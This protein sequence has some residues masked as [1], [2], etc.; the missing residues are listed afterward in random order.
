[1]SITKPWYYV[2]FPNDLYFN[3][4][5]VR[6]LRLVI[7]DETEEIKGLIGD[8]YA[9]LV[10]VW[11]GNENNENNLF[12]NKEI[13]SQYNINGVNAIDYFE[14]IWDDKIQISTK[15]Y[16]TNDFIFGSGGMNVPKEDKWQKISY[17]NF[18]EWRIDY[19]GEKTERIK[20]VLLLSKEL[21]EKIDEIIGNQLD[22]N[23]IG[24]FGIKD[25]FS[26][27]T[28]TE[29]GPFLD[30]VDV[31]IL[32]IAYDKVDNKVN[33]SEYQLD[34]KA[35]FENK[36]S[37][38][39]IR[40]NP[41]LSGNIKV[42]VD[43]ENNVWLNSIDANN[44]LANSRYKRYKVSPLSQYATD[45]YRFFDNGQTPPDIVFDLKQYDS[46]YKFTKQEYYLQY[47]NFYGC[48]VQRMSNRLYSEEF[49]FLAPIWLKKTLPE[50]FVIFKVDHPISLASYNNEEDKEILKDVFKNASILKTFDLREG[51]KIGNYLRNIVN[52]IR[53]KEEPLFIT[54]D[55]ESLSTWSGI[56]YNDGN[57]TEK[58]E[59][60]YNIFTVDRTIKEFEEYITEGFKR[61]SIICQNLINLE[62][63]FNDDISEE[64]SINR[65]F[66]FFVNEIELDRFNPSE[67]ILTKLFEQ[68]P[69]PRKGID[70]VPY[71]MNSFYQE[72]K[73]G[74]VLP[75]IESDKNK[76]TLEND[77]D[78][79]LTK[80]SEDKGKILTVRNRDNEFYRIQD[81]QNREDYKEI[82]LYDNKVDI[83][84]FAGID[85]FSSMLKADLLDESSA[86]M[87]IHLYDTNKDQYI[88]KPGELL[89]I[90]WQE[91]S[92]FH[93][94]E[95]I[96]NE[97]AIQPEDWWDFPIYNNDT[98]TYQNTFNP[99]G[100]PE[101][102]AKAIAGCIN[103][104][105]SNQFEAIAIDNKVFIITIKKFVGGNLFKLKRTFVEGSSIMNVKYYDKEPEVKQLYNY[106]DYTVQYDRVTEEDILLD[107]TLILGNIKLNSENKPAELE[108]EYFDI[109][110]EVLKLKN[111]VVSELPEKGNSNYFYH[112]FIKEDEENEGIDLYYIWIQ[113]EFKIAEFLD[114]YTSYNFIGGN[115]RKRNRAKIE[116]INGSNIEEN[117]WFQC[118]SQK[119]SKI[120]SFEIG[121]SRDLKNQF[122]TNTIIVLPY[123]DEPIRGKGGKL[124]GFQDLE[125][126]VSIQL[127]DDFEFYTTKE[128]YISAYK[129]FKTPISI[130]SVLPIKDFDFDFFF[131]DYSY[132]PTVELLKYFEFYE[133]KKGE[134]VELSNNEFFRVIGGGGTLLGYKNG[135]WKDIC[136]F[137]EILGENV[138][139]TIPLVLEYQV[140]IED[141]GDVPN[142]F[143]TYKVI[144]K[145]EKFKVIALENIKDTKIVKY[146]Y[147]QQWNDKDFNAKRK[148]TLDNLDYSMLDFPGF[149]GLKGLI[150]ESGDLLQ[151]KLKEN[152]D[153]R[154]FLLPFLKTEYDYLLENENKYFVSKSRVVPYI[155]KWVHSGTDVHDNNYR[156]NISNAFGLTNFS[157]STEILVDPSLFTH[158]WYYLDRHPENYPIE[159]LENSRSYMFSKLDEIPF[160]IPEKGKIERK[161][162]KTWKEL[163]YFSREDDPNYFLKYFTEGYPTNISHENLIIK[164]KSERYVFTEFIKG[165][166]QV[167]CL[168]RGARLR[169]NELDN[170]GEIIKNSKKYQGYKFTSILT[171]KTKEFYKYTPP[172]SIEVIDNQRFKTITFIIS[173]FIQDYKLKDHLSYSSLYTLNSVQKIDSAF[174]N[175]YSENI[176]IDDRRKIMSNNQFVSVADYDDTQ[177][178]LMFRPV[179]NIDI[180]RKRLKDNNLIEESF[181]QKDL[182]NLEE[183]FNLKTEE[184]EENQIIDFT[185]ICSF[186]K[187]L[188]K[189]YDPLPFIIATISTF[190]SNFGYKFKFNAFLPIEGNIRKSIFDLL[191]N[192]IIVD[193]TAIPSTK[194][195]LDYIQ[196]SKNN[197]FNNNFN[198]IISINNDNTTEVFALNG[199]KDYNKEIGELIS[200]N[201]I[202]NFINFNNK[203]VEYISIES[204][205]TIHNSKKGDQ[206][207]SLEFIEPNEFAKFDIM[208]PIIDS[209]IPS[210]L[211]THQVIGYDTKKV[212][213]FKKLQRYGGFYGPKSKNI[214]KYN[215]SEK[216][217]VNKFFEKDFTLLNTTLNFDI[218]NNSIIKN[219]SINKITPDSIPI[220]TG[221]LTYFNKY[222]LVNKVAIDNKNHNIVLSNW[223]NNYYRDYSINS[224]DFEEIE[225]IKEMQEI[226]SYFGGKVMNIKKEYKLD[227]FNNQEF[228]IELISPTGNNINTKESTKN[229]FDGGQLKLEISLDLRNRMIRYLFADNIEKEFYW[230]KNNSNS[231][232]SEKTSNEISGIVQNY[233]DKNIIE[234]FEIDS[235]L[236]YTKEEIRSYEINEDENNIIP[237]R[238]Y[239]LR[240]EESEV[241]LIKQGFRRD[242]SFIFEKNDI[243]KLLAK[244]T[245]FL[246][247]NLYKNIGI[248][249]KL[250]RI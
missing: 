159:F 76:F 202:K 73:N 138:F 95:M 29:F 160:P 38:M 46:E 189:S 59:N 90:E 82:K 98:F 47:D 242:K 158:E 129:I 198:F 220:I 137:S 168:F 140:K 249:T 74:V 240:L 23:D 217:T 149:S 52:N 237:E 105:N 1:M 10:P 215:L 8:I 18:Y 234:I 5:T 206:V 226:K 51:T 247:T 174:R 107:S 143:R 100:R 7:E 154:R 223:D 43:S 152:E 132:T 16:G 191:S 55:K 2:N 92:E 146:L 246:D 6:F 179:G 136:E 184:I 11:L 221:E 170:L 144:D 196:Y 130:L 219:L 186:D 19:Y 131:S 34:D 63:L 21:P 165:L 182:G 80:F 48:G 114:E 171:L 56:S 106:K 113:N 50:F 229:T 103:Q 102:V 231:S 243:D 145:F 248:V 203:L 45:L 79:F 44:D 86:Q 197:N 30:Y 33:I 244:I 13:I 128:S 71:N 53:F 9:C 126:F 66:G 77:T 218:T 36:T 4:K 40:T 225:G 216:D 65:Y 61:H 177:I 120:K 241:D 139:N 183:I 173:V 157:P 69:T 250:K 185:H 148:V 20:F 96:A 141:P 228:K 60:L 195:I 188:N 17:G 94:W 42:T 194:K 161:H 180:D 134:E 227:Q 70:V 142:D 83:S 213:T 32:G 58:G 239:T 212:N 119:F 110:I 162:G 163:F 211:K 35:I 147:S 39:L 115:S 155:N 166:N 64:Y 121:I 235:I 178:N 89:T 233:I 112:H 153:F 207:F 87:V 85:K 91:N 31:D 28:G 232:F 205:G 78:N 108:R 224:T 192:F 88:F 24:N 238:F 127:N 26:E 230:V 117:D 151:L 12:K 37:N 68:N 176:F 111:I 123:L 15:F 201:N 150:T 97:T 190:F 84:K 208:Q 199:G 135:V 99:K 81:I 101:Q 116:I 204:N 245:V 172:I 3:G 200:F 222:P 187:F 156:L 175:N 72:N 27:Y 67:I 164:E 236:L 122:V 193:W 41:L 14:T 118:Q 133:L 54:F 210:E 25:Y 49:S 57:V 125:R 62:F 124:L 109:E 75:L 181:I 104:F 169:I 214:L 22:P 209:D 167:H 93:K